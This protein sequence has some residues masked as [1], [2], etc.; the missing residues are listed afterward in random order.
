[1]S[2]ASGGSRPRSGNAALGS[3]LE[4]VGAGS[5]GGAKKSGRGNY[6]SLGPHFQRGRCTRVGDVFEVTPHPMRP[7]S[8]D[9]ALSALMC[10]NRG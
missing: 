4:A 10:I 2:A 5:F 9:H 7:P 8:Q 3:R 6:A 1:M